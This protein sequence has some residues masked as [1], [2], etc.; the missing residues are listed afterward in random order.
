MGKGGA[1]VDAV[2]LVKGSDREVFMKVERK[3]K[4]VTLATMREL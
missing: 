4:G 1:E 2:V 3:E